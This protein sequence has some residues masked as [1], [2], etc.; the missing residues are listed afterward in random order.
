MAQFLVVRPLMP[1]PDEIKE[2]RILNDA[3]LAGERI[4]G[5]RFRHNSHVA[6]SGADGVRCEGWIVSVE[7]AKPE[8][9][10]TVECCDGSGDEEVLESKIELILDPHETPAA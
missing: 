3:F 4:L 6:F 10:Y 9:I 7:P 1:S 5:I 8:P 2:R